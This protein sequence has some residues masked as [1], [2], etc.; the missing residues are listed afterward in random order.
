MFYDDYFDRAMAEN[1]LSVV[2]GGIHVSM[3]GGSYF[4][5]GIVEGGAGSTFGL[6][7]LLV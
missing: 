2:C 5:N 7:E 3:E 4:Y 6:W 1:E